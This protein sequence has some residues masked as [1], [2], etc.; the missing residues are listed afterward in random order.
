MVRD[1][2]VQ[3]SSIRVRSANFAYGE[4][5][6]DGGPLGRHTAHPA[7]KGCQHSLA[8][9][10]QSNQHTPGYPQTQQWSS[11]CLL[12]GK[13]PAPIG[14]D[15]CR[16][17]T[18]QAFLDPAPCCHLAVMKNESTAAQEFHWLRIT[19]AAKSTLWQLWEHVTNAIG[20]FVLSVKVVRVCVEVW[21]SVLTLGNQSS[22]CLQFVVK[23]KNEPKISQSPPGPFVTGSDS[24]C[25]QRFGNQSSNAGRGMKM[26]HARRTDA[27][28][29]C[30]S[31]PW[32]FI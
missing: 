14:T 3:I 6:W 32:R 26:T 9:A 7:T 18:C 25:F 2:V 23:T 21:S 13:W 28:V 31:W 10:P 5:V 19:A 20:R 4:E 27:C 29:S 15:A 12:P 1:V 11:R 8:A 30:H 22:A 16:H 24:L 17:P